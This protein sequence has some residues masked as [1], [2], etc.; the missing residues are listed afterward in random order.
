MGIQDGKV[1]Q[2][3]M[4]GSEFPSEEPII[5]LEDNGAAFLNRAKKKTMF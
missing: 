5:I 4:K 1:G 2:N 3:Y